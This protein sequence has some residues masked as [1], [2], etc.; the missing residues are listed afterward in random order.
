MFMVLYETMDIK[1]A[2]HLTEATKVHDLID[3]VTDLGIQFS[4]TQNINGDIFI[5]KI[6]L[7]DVSERSLK[8]LT[9]FLNA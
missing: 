6:R 1:I 3:M 4:M 9:D 7:H 5:Y 2:S 8:L